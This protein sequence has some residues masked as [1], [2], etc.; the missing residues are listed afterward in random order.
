ML[1]NCA[2]LDLAFETFKRLMLWQGS[3]RVIKLD[4]QV[5]R[6]I[7]KAVWVEQ[8]R[9]VGRILFVYDKIFPYQLTSTIYVFIVIQ[10][11]PNTR[12]VRDFLYRIYIVFSIAIYLFFK[13][14]DC[15]GAKLDIDVF[16]LG[17]FQDTF[18][19]SSQVLC[20]RCIGRA[21]PLILLDE[22]WSLG[23]H[24]NTPLSRH[25]P[26]DRLLTHIYCRTMAFERTS[27][28]QARQHAPMDNNIDM[29]RVRGFDIAFIKTRLFH[30]SCWS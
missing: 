3:A 12:E 24:R 11:N 15:L 10:Y 29:A 9:F 22:S 4:N 21:Q 6:S 26:D 20:E 18:K 14:F 30:V 16:Y 17:V 7:A 28:R 13:A 23:C 25:P 19:N 2:N 1:K 8:V 5:D 27:P